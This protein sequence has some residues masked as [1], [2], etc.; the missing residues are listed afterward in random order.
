VKDRQVTVKRGLEEILNMVVPSGLP[1]SGALG[2]GDTGGKVEF[3]N[4]YARDL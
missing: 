4:L 2:L 3:M 1:E